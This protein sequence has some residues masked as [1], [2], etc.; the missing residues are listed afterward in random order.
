MSRRFIGIE[1]GASRLRAVQLVRMRGAWIVERAAEQPLPPGAASQENG[2]ALRDA[3][4]ALIRDG[5][6]RAGVP[7]AVSMP[8]GSVFFQSL[9]TD[10]DKLDDVRRVIAFETEGDFPFQPGDAV[11]EIASVRKLPDHRQRIL[12]SAVS[13]R[14]LERIQRALREARIEC[15]ALDASACALLPMAALSDAHAGDA[16]IALNLSEGQALLTIT[17]EGKP[18]GVRSFTVPKGSP[19]A[20]AQEWLREMELSWRDV[21][22]VVLPPEVHC[23]VGGEEIAGA[24]RDELAKRAGMQVGELNAFAGFTPPQPGPKGGPYTV[25]AGLALEA[26]GEFHGMNFP[27]AA[28][29]RLDAAQRT[30]QGLLFGAVLLV[31]VVAAWAAGQATNLRALRGRETAVRRETDAIERKLFP[32]SPGGNRPQDVLTEAKAQFDQQQKEYA[33]LGALSGSMPSPLELLD[34]ISKRIPARIP[35]KISELDIKEANASV[36]MVGTTDSYKTVDTI[37]KLLQDARE[38]DKVSCVGELDP[39][40]RTGASI[41]FVATFSFRSKNN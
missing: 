30:R 11:L 7:T 35:M 27:A 41:R 34:L 19:E 6:F 29:A 5:G 40:D 18:A 33:A 4:K 9:D 15:T 39:A 37:K 14:A 1:I 16:F 28:S 20:V 22:G 24:L 21:F 25:A 10:L 8:P 12:V 3:L 2:D 36:R 31:A 13:R 17:A 38:F 23:L 32:N 26:A